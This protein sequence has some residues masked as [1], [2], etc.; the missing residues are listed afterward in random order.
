[1]VRKSRQWYREHA[2]PERDTTPLT[3]EDE[4]QQIKDG[5]W[6]AYPL[7]AWLVGVPKLFYPHYEQTETTLWIPFIVRKTTTT[8]QTFDERFETPKE[9][10]EGTLPYLVARV[11]V[12]VFVITLIYALVK[13]S[14][15]TY[16]ASIVCTFIMTPGFYVKNNWSNEVALRSTW[17]FFLIPGAIVWLVGCL[18]TPSCL[19]ETSGIPIAHN[20]VPVPGALAGVSVVAWLVLRCYAQQNP[21]QPTGQKKQ[22]GGTEKYAEGNAAA[23]AYRQLPDTTPAPMPIAQPQPQL[24]AITVPQG[25][26]PG[27]QIQINTA[28]GLM[29]VVVPAG[30]G[31]GS[32]FNV[33]I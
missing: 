12:L 25:V 16:W 5:R 15:H 20:L 6:P 30:C 7:P 13:A 28:K 33:Q 4:A 21:Y 9:A 8:S 19:T 23:G 29:Q 26:V 31:P 1:M 32:T 14:A 3:P 2:H 24:L 10:R 17:G 27:Q 22:P 11:C 18:L